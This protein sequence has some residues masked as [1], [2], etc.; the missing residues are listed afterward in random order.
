MHTIYNL[1]ELVF[2][3][4]IRCTH[5]H[6]RTHTDTHNTHTHAHTETHTYIF[7]CIYTYTYR[8]THTHTH[9]YIYTYLRTYIRSPKRQHK[10]RQDIVRFGAFPPMARSSLAAYA[11]ELIRVA[12]VRFGVRV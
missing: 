5:T 4:H 2:C 1:D 8:Y 7:V 6:R 3:D 9:I 10:A 12:A 11:Y